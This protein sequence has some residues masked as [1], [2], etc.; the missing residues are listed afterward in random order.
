MMTT[1]EL[2]SHDQVAA[3]ARDHLATLGP[4]ADRAMTAWAL[5][6]LSAN[7]CLELAGYLATGDPRQLGHEY[8]GY[9]GDGLEYLFT[10]KAAEA[11]SPS[12]VRVRVSWREVA[13]LVDPVLA[14][15]QVRDA[16]E[17]ALRERGAF[18]CAHGEP[19]GTDAWYRIE[20]HCHNLAAEVWA[21]CRPAAEQ[22]DL[23]A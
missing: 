9:H 23:F 10:R 3:A 2:H 22:L 18:V 14:R 20:D 5:G 21:T 17:A 4:A 8:S 13:A 15:P 6:A 1:H 11:H 19:W 7:H 16:I 12:G